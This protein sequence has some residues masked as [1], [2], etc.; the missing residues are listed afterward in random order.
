[1]A[2][3]AAAPRTSVAPDITARPRRRTRISRHALGPLLMVGG[4]LVVAAGAL[5]FWLTSGRYVSVDDAYV[6]AAKEPLSTDVSGIVA[7][8][9]VKDGQHVSKGQVL[10]R[11]VTRRFEIAR[12]GAKADLAA[13]ALRLEATKRD[14]QRMLRDIEVK[15]SEVQSDQAN[16]DRYAM[17]VKNG[18]VTRADYD[19]ARFH[20]AADQHA[21]DSLT[22]QAEV[23]L[24]KLGGNPGVNV[25]TLPDYLA[26]QAKVDEAERQLDDA[27]IRAPYDGTVTQV[28]TIQPGMYLAAAT[29]AF[30]LV[31]SERVWV[32]A[33]PKETELTW[34][35]PGDH[36]A[37]TVD[38]Y[39]G[40]TWD[41]VV[42]SIS[43]NSGSEFSVLPA[44]N[45]SGNWV[46]VV[47]RIPVRVRVERH[48]GDPELR[49]GM[50]VEVS[51][52][53]GHSRALADLF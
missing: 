42:E 7:A 46:K 15:R 47:Q 32:E 18:G 26:A 19:N 22:M 12:A 3:M 35:Q 31:S 34:V 5:T 50:S 33:N 17:L 43:P 9:P 36:V 6:Q 49:S 16:Y 37:V 30:G 4:I 45:T 53:T 44:Q 48:A 20:L 51:I 14:Y 27:V 21:L 52:D 28:D 8:V 38:T 2:Q 11:L 1:M 29:A 10:L 24:A 41:G 23:Q 13:T 39:P 25:T 40:R